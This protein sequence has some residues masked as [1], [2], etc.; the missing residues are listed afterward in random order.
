VPEIELLGSRL[1]QAFAG[2]AWHGPAMEQVLRGVDAAAAAAHPWHGVHS[3][4][5]VVLHVTAW[6]KAVLRRMQGEVVELTH[7]QDWPQVL[8]FSDSQ[9]QTDLGALAESH[10]A[11]CAAVRGFS[12]AHLKDPVPG[13][14]YNFDFMLHGAADHIVYHAGQIALLKK[15]L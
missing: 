12:A 3:V 2:V 4:W 8:R 1:K 5:E 15:Q 14:Q 9:W 6:N 13:A 11:L 7:Q 10:A